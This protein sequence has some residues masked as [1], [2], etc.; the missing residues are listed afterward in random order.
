LDLW[1]DSDREHL[2]KNAATPYYRRPDMLLMFPK[3][4][5]QT[6]KSPDPN[7]KHR[8]LSDIVF[9]SSRDG[10][11]WDRRFREA[12]LRP[13]RDRL[14]WHE[15]AIEAG[16]G[17]VPTGDGEMSLYFIEHYRTESVRSRR[18]YS[19]RDSRQDGQSACGLR[20]GRVR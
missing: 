12:F 6:R 13:G 10:I 5:L 7:W 16:P 14:N 4:Y 11:H 2:Y 17:L 8:G 19:R 1:G 3:R 15:W 20:V 18:Q 9:M